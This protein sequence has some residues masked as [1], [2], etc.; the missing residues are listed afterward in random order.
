MESFKR[1]ENFILPEEPSGGI[2]VGLCDLTLCEKHP[3]YIINMRKWHEPKAR[4]LNESKDSEQL[5]EVC[6][7]GAVMAR[8]VDN[9][10]VLINSCKP[11]TSPFNRR[12]RALDDLRL[13][14]IVEGVCTY[15]GP[16]EYE[17]LSNDTRGSLKAIENYFKETGWF[18]YVDSALVFKKQLY[19]VADKLEVIGL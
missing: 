12:I 19:R 16:V 13:G 6:L 8:T 4:K 10:L 3:R 7:G 14:Y 1:A 5:C 15:L 18:T 9:P 17:K 11:S 2:R